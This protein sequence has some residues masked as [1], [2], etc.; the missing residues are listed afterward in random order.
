M[1]TVA[2]ISQR[3]VA[4]V[5]QSYSIYSTSVVVV[6]RASLLVEG[7]PIGGAIPETEVSL[8]RA[9]SGV[10]SATPMLF[11]VNFEHLVPNN[12][13][14]GIPVQNF[15]MFSRTNSIQLE[16]GY[17]KSDNEVVVGRNLAEAS[18]LAVGSTLR[19]GSASFM[20]SGV[21]ST[22]NLILSNAV[23]MPLEAAQATQGYSGL[24]SAI[25]VSSNGVQTDALIQAINTEVPGVQAIDPA[26]SETFTGPL[27][28]AIGVISYG[29]DAFSITLA[30]LFVAIIAGVN[31]LEQKEEFYTMQ[32]IGSSSNSILK[33]TLAEMGLVSSVGFV[34]GL[35]LSEVTVAASLQEF[36][37][38]PFTVSI[39]NPATLLPLPLV[40]LA[41]AIVVGFGMLIGG[42]TATAI[43]RRQA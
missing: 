20:V 35:V 38:I 24:V 1:L 15:S 32:A 14:I 11:V 42:V 39:S 9:A 17:P 22:S 3:G 7:L 10:T 18:G 16:G 33:V 30:F 31:M 6:S 37:S 19:V 34:L 2:A 23:I 29:T 28:S 21:I 12:V 5:D 43:L 36:A 41:G 8:V 13:T 25:L 40:L 4:V 27:V 26:Q